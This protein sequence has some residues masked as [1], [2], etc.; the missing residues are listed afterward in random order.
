VS[1]DWYQEH[2]SDHGLCFFRWIDGQIE[3]GLD[4]W[5]FHM[6]MLNEI[7]DAQS[8]YL[9]IFLQVKDMERADIPRAAP[10][11]PFAPQRAAV[12]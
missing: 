7:K 9:R 10:R 11:T 1:I 4:P 12:A 2:G 8:R 3:D 5:R 6:D